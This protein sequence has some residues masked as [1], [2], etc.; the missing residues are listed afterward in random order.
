[1]APSATRPDLRLPRPD[2]SNISRGGTGGAEALRRRDRPSITA[3]YLTPVSL[4]L[5]LNK[6]NLN[7]NNLNSE[8]EHSTIHHCRLLNACQPAPSPPRLGVGSAEYVLGI[9]RER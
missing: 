8:P 6:C 9:S 4:D 3:T 1:M 5:N 7:L 2:L